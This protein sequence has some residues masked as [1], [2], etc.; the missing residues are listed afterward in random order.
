MH[1]LGDIPGQVSTLKKKNING[2]HKRHQS[3]IRVK[4][5]FVFKNYINY[6]TAIKKLLQHQ[7]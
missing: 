6:R 1:Q 3:S 7:S 2:Q 5:K 4:G